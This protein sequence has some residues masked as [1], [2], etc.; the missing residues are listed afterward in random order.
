MVRLVLTGLTCL[1]VT[2]SLSVVKAQN[3]KFLNLSAWEV[4]LKECA[5][6]PEATAAVLVDEGSSAYNQ[7]Y[8]LISFN[9]IRMKI[10]KPEGLKYGNVTVRYYTENDF[11]YLSEI[12]AVTIN[13]DENG[14]RHEYPVE[15]KNIYFKKI[16]NN[17]GEMSFAF[18]QLKVGSIIEYKYNSTMKHY[19]GLRDWNF[20]SNLPVYLSS[21]ILRPAPNLEFTYLVQRSGNYPVDIKQ[22]KTDGAV[23]F[24]MKNIPGLGEEPFMDA[25][26]D[27]IQKIHFQITKIAGIA[28]A[29]KYMSS[30]NQVAQELSSDSEYGG[31]LRAN[32][33]E[34]GK[35]FLASLGSLNEIDKLR[36]IYN[37]V[38]R[39]FNWNNYIGRYPDPGVKTLWSKKIGNSAAINLALVNMLQEVKIESYPLLVSD[40]GN[41]RINTKT[42]FISQFNNTYA[43]AVINGVSY[44]LDATDMFTPAHITPYNILNTTALLIKG[45][46]GVLTE[47]TE[48]KHRY[49]DLILVTSNLSD[50]G[51]IS[52][53]VQIA[54]K[55]YARSTR[56]KTYAANK[57]DYIESVL[58]REVANIEIDSL[59]IENLND[60]T[61]SLEQNFTYRG[62]IQN[63]GDYSFLITN[64]FSGFNTNPFLSDKRFSNINFGHKRMLVYNY[65]VHL[66]KNM[67]ID[68][69]PKSL[70]IINQDKT[71]SF[72]RE[73]FYS[74]EANQLVVR[75][76]LEHGKSLYSVDEYG[77]LKEFYK[78]MTDLVNEQ[79]V[80]KKRS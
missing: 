30:W 22:D 24:E 52:G 9:H 8:N 58:K 45:K 28:G 46:T 65:Q 32:V 36:A 44:Y 80:L 41:G 70:K 4:D 43:V 56:Y 74:K 55:E 11:E 69:L 25:R 2:F 49:T 54:S 5:F 64:L 50:D 37:Y 63:T 42:P 40:R 13:I 34:E 73:L 62:N 31:Q 76:R 21:Y 17:F 18:P 72:A 60:D 53:R 51:N 12:S 61:L 23:Y 6:D 7:E 1:V 78:K 15:R 26:E 79:V 71:I 59:E 33:P 35:A 68:E 47:I 16:N 19:E 77:D 75:M 67:E 38:R 48:E 20:Q 3:K 29:Q 14:Q 27:Y 39:T 66:P 10:L 57:K